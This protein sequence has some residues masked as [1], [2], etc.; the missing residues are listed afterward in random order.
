MKTCT[1]CKELKPRSEFYFSD[2][3]RINLKSRCKK[4]H[5]ARS[6]QRH[7]ENPDRT[8][9][10]K[11]WAQKNKEKMRGYRLKCR[12]GISV[13]EYDLLLEKQ[14][15]VCAICQ[16]P[17]A[18]VDPRYLTPRKLAVDHCHKSGKIRG[19]LCYACNTSIGKFGDDI[20]TIKNI[21][22]YLGAS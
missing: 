15:G 4:C 16:K 5:V 6:V 19:L 9:W 10:E 17:E 14:N 12:Y 1:K 11:T 20:E 22:T 21:L 2:G 8:I 18:V 13:E 7:R 3:K